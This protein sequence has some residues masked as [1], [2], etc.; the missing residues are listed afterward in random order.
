MIEDTGSQGWN[1]KMDALEANW[2]ERMVESQR[3]YLS[4]YVS[5]YGCRLENS[6]EKST[7]V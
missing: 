4:E 6:T 3:E 1:N 7:P 2:R 5:L